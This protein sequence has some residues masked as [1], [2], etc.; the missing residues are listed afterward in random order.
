[1]SFPETAEI[2][3]LNNLDPGFVYPDLFMSACSPAFSER[4]S[5][6]FRSAN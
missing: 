3:L 2:Y 4:Q 6:G 5:W 1:M